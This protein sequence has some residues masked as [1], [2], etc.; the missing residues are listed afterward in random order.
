MESPKAKMSS[1]TLHLYDECQTPNVECPISKG[2][3]DTLRIPKLSTFDIR[4][5]TFDMVSFYSN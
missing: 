5:L 4:R 3:Q 2:M 1:Q